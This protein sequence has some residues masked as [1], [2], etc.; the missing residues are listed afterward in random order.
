MENSNPPKLQ[1]VFKPRRKSITCAGAGIGCLGFALL[2]GALA[3]YFVCGK[4]T[5]QLSALLPLPVIRDTVWVVQKPADEPP[6]AEKPKPTFQGIARRFL[7][8][9]K[10]VPGLAPGDRLFLERKF[11]GAAKFFKKASDTTTDAQLAKEAE[12]RLLLAQLAQ[13]PKNCGD[14]E[15]RLDKILEDKTH[16]HF[17]EAGQL[18][19]AVSTLLSED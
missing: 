4:K 9:T 14:F 11:I 16:P 13:C 3:W 5:E 8:A 18:K 6:L 10:L 15:Q 19:A 1:P 2:G 7:V 12:W 17:A